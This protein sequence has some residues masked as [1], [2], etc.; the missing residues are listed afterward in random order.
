M[1]TI[2]VLDCIQNIGQK[3]DLSGWVHSIRNHKKVVFIDLRDR[4]GII[5]VVGDE[6][7]T[8]LSPEDVVTISGFIKERP[9][10]M[11]NSKIETGGVEIEASG[12]TLL[13]KA[14]ILPID[15]SKEKLD[16]TLPVL[17]DHRALTL[18]HPK[19]SAIFLIQQTVIDA[20]REGLTK[21]GF[22]EFQ[23]PVIIPQ[24]A[25]GGAEVFE[26]SYFN[27]KAFLSQS[28]QFYKQIMVGVF[29]KVF[30]VNKTLRAEPSVTTR[31]LTEVTTLDAEM[32]FIS[33]WEDIMDTA[34]YSIRY[35]FERIKKDRNTILK[36]FNIKMPEVAKK[37]PR[38]KLR[39]ALEIIYKN[40]GRDHRKEP[41]LAP[42]DERDICAWAHKEY[43]SDL[44]FITHYP[45]SKRPFYTYEDPN[46]T[47]YTLSF[48]LI[49]RGVEWL[50]GG[51]R[52]NDYDLLLQKA[53]ERNIDLEKSELYLQAFR[54]GLP[55]HGGFSFGSERIT[56]KILQLDNIRQASLFPRDMERIDIH[57][58]SLYA[59][60]TKKKTV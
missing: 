38:I 58:P 11:K 53:K 22:V 4:T 44:I 40:T 49:G 6:S 34:E 29:E 42:D 5:Q 59:K 14:H 35:I 43:G 2:Y 23:A 57:L 55:P 41:D 16:V 9:D 30:T 48:D 54:Y 51:Q 19:I 47:G 15:I 8:T 21:A 7:F 12:F 52:I 18:R 3:V 39:E 10:H 46:D 13:A 26:V 36:S 32:G 60:K 1:K 27:T 37:I 17:L 31:H 33:S 56:M 24:T 25:E 45:V 20:F 50:T 28:P